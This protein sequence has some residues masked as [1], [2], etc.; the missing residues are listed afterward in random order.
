MYLT[1]PVESRLKHLVEE[2]RCLGEFR[3]WWIWD[4]IIGRKLQSFLK[5]RFLYD[6]ITILERWLCSCVF[7]L[8]ASTCWVEDSSVVTV[9][10]SQLC[11]GGSMGVVLAWSTAW[12]VPWI[13]GR[14]LPWS[15]LGQQLWDTHWLLATI[16]VSVLMSIIWWWAGISS[17]K[18]IV[19]EKCW[20]D[21]WV[22]IFLNVMHWQGT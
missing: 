10:G 15:T 21:Y 1:S 7:T 18:H 13:T 12:M 8:L 2:Q 19:S 20:R 6:K 9:R 14:R 11:Y 22:N 5:S 4:V 3:W 16:M 17:A